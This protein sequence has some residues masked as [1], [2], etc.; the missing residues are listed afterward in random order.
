MVALPRRRRVLPAVLTAV[1][2]AA[3]AITILIDIIAVQTGHRALIWPYQQ[4]A[5]W[6]RTHPWNTALVVVIAAVVT[7]LGVLLIMTALIPGKHTLIALDTGEVDLVAGTSRRSLARTLSEAARSVDGISAAKATPRRRTLRVKATSGLRDPAGQQEQVSAAVTGRGNRYGLFLTGL[8]LLIGGGLALARSLGAFNHPVPLL[9]PA[10]AGSP[11]LSQPETDYVHGA[12]WLW[13][14]VGVAAA[15]LTLVCLR[16]L[17]TQLRTDRVGTLQ[18]EPD[19]THGGTRI[20]SGVITAAVQDEVGSYRGVHQVR[21]RL[22]NNPAE[23]ELH[24]TISA[25]RHTDLRR[26][27]TRIHD[28]AIPHVRGAL[29]LDRLP[30]QLTLRLD[31]ARPTTR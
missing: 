1:A 18:L 15:L 30:V 13:P 7:A 21:A 14:V 24:L 23:P 19:R 8:V 29:E 2:L 17:L 5:T 27:R 4:I 31:T 20:S 9:G 10:S 11:L 6:G 16:W 3:A 22:T 25:E 12:S 28:E 26:L